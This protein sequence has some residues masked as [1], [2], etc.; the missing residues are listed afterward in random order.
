MKFQV[1][2]SQVYYEYYPV[3]RAKIEALNLGFTFDESND[4]K[5]QGDVTIV[6]N[7]LEELM[8]LVRQLEGTEIILSEG[9]IE[10]YNGYRE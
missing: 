8:D 7:S 5:I 4:S 1:F 6:L 2:T 3:R 10:I 9:S